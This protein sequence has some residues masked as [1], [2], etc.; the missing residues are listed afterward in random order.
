MTNDR[1]HPLPAEWSVQEALQAYLD[2]NG[3]TV[4]AYDERRTQAAFL[5]LRFS[6]PNP[7]RHRWAIMR[8]DLHH[9]ATGYGTDLRGEGEISAFELRG[10]VRALGLYTGSIVVIGALMGLLLAPIRTCRAWRASVGRSLL[11]TERECGYEELLGLSVGQ[12]RER[13]GLPAVGLSER[14]RGLYS[15][16]PRR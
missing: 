15:S 2:E 1:D 8:H 12:L 11:G 5:G 13:L 16:A 7:P 14:R 3:F 4:A 6:V 10:G 9:V